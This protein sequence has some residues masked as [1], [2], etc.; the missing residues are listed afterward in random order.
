MDVTVNGAPTDLRPGTV[1]DAVVTA[2]GI[3]PTGSAVAVNGVVVPRS[4]WS[5]VAL[6]PGDTVEVLTAVQGG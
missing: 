2:L 4:E 6:A 1:V 3:G 5:R